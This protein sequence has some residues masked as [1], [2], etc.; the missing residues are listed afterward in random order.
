[1]VQDLKI[2]VRRIVLHWRSLSASWDQ[3]AVRARFMQLGTILQPIPVV[4]PSD[5]HC[6]LKVGL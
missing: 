1:M 2:N 5:L 4:I 3:L 6:E